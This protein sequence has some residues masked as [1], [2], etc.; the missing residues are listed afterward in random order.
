[1]GLFEFRG[2]RFSMKFTFDASYFLHHNLGMKGKFSEDALSAESR[3]VEHNPMELAIRVLLRA[4]ARDVVNDFALRPLLAKRAKTAST[5]TSKSNVSSVPK[6]EGFV[7]VNSPIAGAPTVTLKP[8][9]VAKNGLRWA[10]FRWK[11]KRR[12]K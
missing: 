10:M 11:M 9:E 4:V 1:M 8:Q 6:S 7:T 12:K 5:G 3:A 2:A